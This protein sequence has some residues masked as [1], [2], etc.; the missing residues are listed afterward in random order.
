[1]EQVHLGEVVQEQVEV[2]EWADHE[3]E[4]W[5]APEQVQVRM[6]NAFVLNVELLYLMKPESLAPT[7]S[8]QN[9]AQK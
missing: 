3:G 6:E 2:R 9:A 8:V 4:G 1:M 5:A 7:S